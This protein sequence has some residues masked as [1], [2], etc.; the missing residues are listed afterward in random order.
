[1]NRTLK[2]F[3]T[4]I[5][6]IGW[7][8]ALGFFAAFWVRLGGWETISRDFADLR[9]GYFLFSLVVLVVAHYAR[10]QL[11]YLST[12]ILGY[13]ITRSEAHRYWL[14]AQIAKYIPGGV[15]M[16]AAKTGQYLRH[17]MPLIVATAAV[18]WELWAIVVVG[19]V[20]GIGSLG[21]IN[22]LD[23][24]VVISVGVAALICGM[25]ASL[26]PALWRFLTSLK[27]PGA[28]KM[29]NMLNSLGKKRFALAI[30]LSL[31]AVIVWIIT[32][33]G[34][35]L[36]LLSM[37]MQ[38]LRLDHAIT[39]YALAWT[40]G[41]LVVFAPSGLG[42]REAVITLL[43]T[44]VAGAETAFALAVLARIWWSLGEV[45]HLGWVMI[46]WGYVRATSSER[47][48]QPVLDQK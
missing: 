41:F 24:V 43:I 2:T 22:S 40:L 37:G 17:G 20:I 28:E 14:F 13:P 36:L 11:G 42:P 19:L 12:R 44:P 48:Q 39:S 27:F 29:L 33:A 32:G 10:S 26:S 7:I 5:N 34:F 30:Q 1:M 45:I 31:F 9:W 4:L 46:G 8:I 16:F 35:Y 23:W 38:D 25:I 3:R 6:I 21:L 47:G 15:W 18:T